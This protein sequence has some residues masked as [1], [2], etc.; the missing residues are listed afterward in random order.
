MK[1]EP[2]F[3]RYFSFERASQEDTLAWMQ[4]FM[5]F[6]KKY[7]LS[8]DPDLQRRPVIKSPVHTARGKLLH[9]M[10]PKGQ[11]IYIHRNPYRVFLSASNMAQKT[12]YYM[13]LG[14][15][16]KERIQDFI[17][18]QY[19]TLFDDYMAA[20]KVLPKECLI[21][22][23]YEEITSDLVGTMKKIYDYFKWDGWEAMEAIYKKEA[24]SMK[25]FQ[26]NS[27]IDMDPKLKELVYEKWKDSFDAFGYEK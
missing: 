7:T 14:V 15:P 2:E 11:I 1:A 25:S 3:R 4:S 5:L 23:S 27:F 16:T 17:I 9:K 8:N 22:I 21:E 19:V 20:K 18:N 24:E 26:K 13:Y 6:F 12:Y 10:F